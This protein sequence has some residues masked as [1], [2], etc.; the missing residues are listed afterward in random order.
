MAYATRVCRRRASQIPDRLQSATRRGVTA[1]SKDWD[2]PGAPAAPIGTPVVSEAQFEKEDRSVH[3]VLAQAH[4]EL[5]AR[6]PK[7]LCRMGLILPGLLQRPLDRG[8]LQDTELCRVSCSGR[9][10]RT[11]FLPRLLPGFS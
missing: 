7:Q 8:A 10:D 3:T 9:R 11:L 1:I 5:L 6:Q 4:V 2:V